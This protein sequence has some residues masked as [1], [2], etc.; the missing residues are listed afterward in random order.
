MPASHLGAR[1]RYARRR[2]STEVTFLLNVS[3]WFGPDPISRP[4]PTPQHLGPHTIQVDQLLPVDLITVTGQTRKLR[5]LLQQILTD[6]P[7]NSPSSFTSHLIL[8]RETKKCKTLM[9]MKRLGHTS[10]WQLAPT[11]FFF[12]CF[13][14]SA[15]FSG[16]LFGRLLI[17]VPVQWTI[18][19]S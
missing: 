16:N 6:R 2:L 5:A 14:A 3:A 19:S 11:V 15:Q 13:T 10:K 1:R 17:S 9:E 8:D 12:K 18:C 4:V 7:P